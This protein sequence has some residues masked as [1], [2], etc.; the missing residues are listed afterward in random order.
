MLIVMAIYSISPWDFSQPSITNI[1]HIYNM[2]ITAINPY[3]N[4]KWDFCKKC[5]LKAKL[6][7]MKVKTKIFPYVWSIFFQMYTSLRLLKLQLHPAKVFLFILSLQYFINYTDIVN[8]QTT[9]IQW[10]THFLLLLFKCY[11]SY[12]NVH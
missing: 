6:E 10:P 4:Y 11:K 12:Y 5:V 7:V 1:A 8:N 2:F 3:S 9:S